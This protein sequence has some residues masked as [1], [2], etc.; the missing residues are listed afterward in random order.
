MLKAYRR[1]Q[2]YHKGFDGSD[3]THR[4]RSSVTVRGVSGGKADGNIKRSQTQD[5]RGQKNKADHQGDE[6][7]GRLQ[8]ASGV[9]GKA[10]KRFEPYAVKFAEVLGNLAEIIW[11]QGFESAD[12]AP[13]KVRNVDTPCVSSDRGLCGG[14]QHQSDKQSGKLA[15]EGKPLRVRKCRLHAL[16]KKGRDYFRK[17]RKS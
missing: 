11:S 1:I 13:R 10:W 7:G 14:F 5:R 8:A 4:R 17:N 9:Q 16:G 2:G 12:H 15:H 3:Q 6:H